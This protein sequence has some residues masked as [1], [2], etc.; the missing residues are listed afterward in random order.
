MRRILVLGVGL[1]AILAGPGRASEKEALAVVE[2]AVKVQGGATALEKAQQC[3][4]TDTG[5]QALGGRDAAVHQR[6]DGGLPNKVRLKIELD[7]K[8]STTIVLNGDKGWQSEGGPA[9][10]MFLR[11]RSRSC[12]KKRTCGG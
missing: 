7:K 4:R 12:A 5:T 1:L 9:V 11:R 8:L 6:G 3:E 2:Q 10:Q